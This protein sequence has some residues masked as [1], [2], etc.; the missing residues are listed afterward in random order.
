MEIFVAYAGI[1]LMTGMSFI[2][3]SFGVTICGNAVVGAMKKNPDALGSY[4]A[5][6]ALPSSQGLYG[7][8]AYFIMQKFLVAGISAFAAVAILASGL[9]MG[10]SAIYS[11]FRQAQVC[12]NGIAAIGSGHNV[13]GATMVMAVFP[14]LYAILALLVVI[15]ISGIIPV[16]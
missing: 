6:S 16:L 12:A 4:I 7:F 13:F 11:A 10:F 15:L 5:L 9:I 14:E 1:V 2:G 8:V 3:S